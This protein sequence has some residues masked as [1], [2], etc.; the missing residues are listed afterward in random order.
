MPA[1]D[2]EA[3]ST[4][5]RGASPP[6]R[7]TASAPTPSVSFT[8]LLA[9]ALLVPFVVRLV[10][11]EPYPAIL[12]PNGAGK[13]FFD[14]ADA[15]FERVTLCAQGVRG[16]APLD[17]RRLLMP[18]PGHY[19]FAIARNDFGQDVAPTAPLVIRRVGRYR[20][21]RKVPSA[22]DRLAAR[23]WLLSQ[24]QSLDPDAEEL[25]VRYE[26]VSLN[27]STG[28]ERSTTTREQ[29]ILLR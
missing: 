26:H 7:P 29:D 13:I 17:P 25:V 16:C 12:L 2:V 23:R 11:T 5:L 20:V 1:T 27:M 24:V 18:I 15:H 10:A 19:L 28:Q 8:I 9:A 21:P 3:A 4:D 22:D 14:G 6:P